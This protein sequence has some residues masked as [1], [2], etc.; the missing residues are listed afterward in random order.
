MAYLRWSGSDWYVYAHHG[1]GLMIHYAGQDGSTHLNDMEVRALLTGE[2]PLANIGGWKRAAVCSR[3][4]LLW[5][6]REYLADE[7]KA[8]IAQVEAFKLRLRGQ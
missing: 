1:G 6:L 2:Q 8:T 3:Q 7:L 5:T 4:E